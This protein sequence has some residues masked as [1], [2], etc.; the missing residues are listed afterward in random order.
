MSRLSRTAF[1]ISVGAFAARPVRAASA[2]E[3]RID[4][5]IGSIPGKVSVCVRTMAPGP[6]LF[7]YH[8]RESFPSA[9]TIKLTIMLTAF[10]AA[11]RNPRAL[12]ER[13]VFHSGALIAGSDFMDGATD[14]Q[15]FSVYELLLPMIRLSDNT[16]SNMLISHFGFHRIN[17]VIQAAGLHDT[18]LARHFMDFAAI[19]RHM[20]NRTTAADMAQL[21]WSIERGAR[22]GIATVASPESCRAMIGIMLGQTDRATIPAGVPA[23]VPVANKTGEL[24]R[25]RSDVAIVEPFGDSP[26]VLAVY[27]NDLNAPGDAY[28]GITAISRAVFERLNGTFL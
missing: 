28:A 3:R 16:A 17:A 12:H 15:S 22:E 26:Y 20:D 11:Q 2:F 9:S 14:G 6:A 1:L 8:A 24:S 4:A 27:T 25:S 21:L 19:G 5:A 10:L 18:V 13:V 23:G 7:A